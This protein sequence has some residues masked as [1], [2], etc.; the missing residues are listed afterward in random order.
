[1][2]EEEE[3]EEAWGWVGNRTVGAANTMR[4][5]AWQQTAPSQLTFHQGYGE[6]IG[7]AT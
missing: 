4:A 1:M 7:L 2:R 3:E 5:E 6:R